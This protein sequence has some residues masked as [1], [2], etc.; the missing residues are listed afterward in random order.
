MSSPV[1]I[2]SGI[3]VG[4]V[5]YAHNNNFYISN[6]ID[7]IINCTYDTEFINLDDIKFKI[8][9]PFINDIQSKHNIVVIN[10]YISKVL[11]IMYKSINNHNIFIYSYDMYTIPLSILGIFI[12]KYGNI[13]EDSI[14]HI[15][16]S[17]L[18]L[19]YYNKDISI[20]ISLYRHLIN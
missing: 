13:N 4:D 8:K 15:I 19:D 11:E 9:V 1:E 10:D 14:E 7:I 2:I 6:K 5:N 16:K 20:D 17:K 3:W 18:N 12:I